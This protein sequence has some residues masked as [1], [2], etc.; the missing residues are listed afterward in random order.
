MKV[1]VFVCCLLA[2]VAFNRA[3][4]DTA[5]SPL[6]ASTRTAA[7]TVAVVPFEEPGGETV[8]T[9]AAADH[10]L[11]TDL[12]QR[13]LTVVATAPVRHLDVPKTAAVICKNAG[14]SAIVLGSARTEQNLKLTYAV[15][16][17]IPHYP[18]HAEL[19]LSVLNCSGSVVWRTV[20]VGDR[21]YYWSNVGAAV[22]ETVSMAIDRAVAGTPSP[23]PIVGLP[24]PAV[25]PAASAA[26]IVI[27]PLSEPGSE[28]G[29]LDETTT[30]VL[31][32][33][34][35]Y[36]PTSAAAP[37]MDRF[38]AVNNAPELCAA[39]HSKGI[40]VGSVRTEQTIRTG[41]KSHA[42]TF[43]SFLTCRGTVSWTEHFTAEN[44]HFGSNFRSGASA[45]IA[46]AFDGGRQKI[47]DDLKGTSP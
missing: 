7:V 36:D 46:T 2:S 8:D 18:T 13:G 10:A 47:L 40:M 25:A 22:S 45:A 31:K 24:L 26:G 20:T 27:L 41:L 11:Q 30:Q 21:D 29:L 39:Y 38:D 15:L 32:V 33:A 37:P 12:Q 35:A 3:L 43:V 5:P 16:T 4:A 1:V 28:D 42:E 44:T 19:R 6:P 23:L 14:A 17:N 9:W 34:R